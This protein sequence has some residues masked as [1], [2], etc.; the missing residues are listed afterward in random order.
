MAKSTP[1]NGEVTLLITQYGPFE[2]S[3]SMSP[4][5]PHTYITN[6]VIN[7]DTHLKNKFTIE[8]WTKKKR[9]WLKEENIK[10]FASQTNS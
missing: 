5:S 4:I 1:E 6:S 9:E 7:P 2:N 10:C 8:Y 3:K